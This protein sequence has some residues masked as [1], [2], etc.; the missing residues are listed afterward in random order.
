MT[1][2][3]KASR[4]P[5]F[6]LGQQILK[7]LSAFKKQHWEEFGGL[8]GARVSSLIN[9]V[10]VALI[11]ATDTATN[12]DTAV[13]LGQALYR[14]DRL[15][16][17]AHTDLCTERQATPNA[18]SVNHCYNDNRVNESYT[19]DRDQ[20]VSHRALV[21]MATLLRA[22][23][24][25]PSLLK[26]HPLIDHL[27]NE[28]TLTPAQYSELV[29]YNAATHAAS[30]ARARVTG[31]MDKLPVQ[32][33]SD[34]FVEAKVNCARITPSQGEWPMNKPRVVTLHIGLSAKVEDLQSRSPRERSVDFYDYNHVSGQLVLNSCSIADLSEEA[35]SL[36]KSVADYLPKLCDQS[37]VSP[38]AVPAEIKAAYDVKITGTMSKELEQLHVR[39]RA[40]QAELEDIDARITECTSKLRKFPRAA[41]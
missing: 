8:E 23:Q 32:V 25:A 38:S 29:S 41:A 21:L 6:S 34:V 26:A 40:L 13:Q 22:R 39:R 20:A 35:V 31:W 36:F 16:G 3:I 18:K 14:M 4:F 9:H 28:F 15:R 17:H 5:F 33:H 27:V 7:S 24:S 19:W 2:D 1:I 37:R 30:R 11:V 12:T 10:Q